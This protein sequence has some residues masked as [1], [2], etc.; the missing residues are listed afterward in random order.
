M[1]ND[2]APQH[3]IEIFTNQDIYHMQF[4]PRMNK[5]KQQ[6]EKKLDHK[7]SAHRMEFCNSLDKAIKKIIDKYGSNT[8]M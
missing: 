6:K 4:L 1:A 3:Q 5:Q 8:A 7:E 2:L